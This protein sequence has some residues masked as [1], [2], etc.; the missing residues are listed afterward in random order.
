MGGSVY[1]LDQ[2]Q[3]N[4]ERS[5]IGIIR[6]SWKL[7]SGRWNENSLV[8]GSRGESGSKLLLKMDFGKWKCGQPT[9]PSNIACCHTAQ[10]LLNLA[11]SNF[12]RRLV[13]ISQDW[14]DDGLPL[15]RHDV[16]NP[17]FE[18]QKSIDSSE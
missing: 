3:P 7:H 10:L 14:I 15:R 2:G 5:H 1:L 11:I 8:D 12:E 4:W 17:L 13:T 16:T 6:Q 18:F 9:A